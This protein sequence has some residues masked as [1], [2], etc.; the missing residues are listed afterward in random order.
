[1]LHILSISTIYNKLVKVYNKIYT[2]LIHNNTDTFFP[3]ES[4]LNIC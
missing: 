4:H 2:K 3:L 1:M